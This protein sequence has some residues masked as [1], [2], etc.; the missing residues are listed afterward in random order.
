MSEADYSAQMCAD[1]RDGALDIAIL[2][3][4]PS[5]TPTCISKAWARSPM[6]WSRPRPPTSPSAAG[7]LHPAQLCPR[8]FRDP[9]RAPC[10]CCRSALVSSGQNAVIRGLL[11][12][13]GGS[14]YVPARDR[15]RPRACGG[16]RGG[17]A[18]APVIDQPVLAA[19]HLR[20]RH[21]GA[22]RRLLRALKA[23]LDSRPS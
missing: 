20:N 19:V 6:S 1:V 4:R 3:T 17:W 22:H 16:W 12:A 14:T 2:T 18:R 10:R 23:H 7:Q 8:L 21:R 5:R 15:P 9:C 13:L 11:I